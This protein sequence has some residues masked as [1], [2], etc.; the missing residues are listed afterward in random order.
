MGQIDLGVDEGRV[1]MDVPQDIAD[2]LDRS[3]GGE[4]PRRERVTEQIEPLPAV[5]CASSPARRKAS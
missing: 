3:P 4:Q 1:Q 2:G 5:P